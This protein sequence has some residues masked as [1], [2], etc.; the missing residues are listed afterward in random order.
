MIN[1]DFGKV[2]GVYVMRVLYPLA[3]YPEDRREVV[4]PNVLYAI[5]VRV[6]QRS[7]VSNNTRG[8]LHDSRDLGIALIFNSSA[9]RFSFI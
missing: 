1:L 5:P 7:H 4:R 8:L 9:P 2:I 3:S 6:R